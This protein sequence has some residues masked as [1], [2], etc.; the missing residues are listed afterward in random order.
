M[1]FLAA[2]RMRYAKSSIPQNGKSRRIDLR[3]VKGGRKW[4]RVTV[5]K[6]EILIRWKLGDSMFIIW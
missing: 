3:C 6:C 2:R 1:P 5:E 4:R